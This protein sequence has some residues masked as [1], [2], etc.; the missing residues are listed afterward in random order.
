METIKTQLETHTKLWWW[1]MGKKT[2]S[3]EGTLRDLLKH[4]KITYT[5]RKTEHEGLYKFRFRNNYGI[6]FTARGTIND[7]S[8]L[9]KQMIQMELVRMGDKSQLQV[10]GCW[11]PTVTV[12]F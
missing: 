5:K 11:R 9:A 2:L 6:L 8:H 12:N 1:N 10:N 4:Q 7:F 3:H